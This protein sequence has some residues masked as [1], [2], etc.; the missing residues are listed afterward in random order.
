MGGGGGVQR[1]EFGDVQ[2]SENFKSQSIRQL[3]KIAENQPT[4]RNSMREKSF[5]M[6][7]HAKSA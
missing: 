7:F 4:D 5:A 1:N 2:I 6:P 3:V